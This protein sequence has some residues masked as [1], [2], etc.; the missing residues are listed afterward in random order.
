MALPPHASTSDA[1]NWASPGQKQVD[2]E[3]SNSNL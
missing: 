1:S 3:T 2:T